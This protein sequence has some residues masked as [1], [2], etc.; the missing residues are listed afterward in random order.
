MAAEARRLA[1]SRVSP[2]VPFGLACYREILVVAA[3]RNNLD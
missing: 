1:N 2:V 3:V